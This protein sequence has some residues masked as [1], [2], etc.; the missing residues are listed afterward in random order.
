MVHGLHID[1]Q[2]RSVLAVLPEVTPLLNLQK[3]LLFEQNFGIHKADSEIF[4]SRF[5]EIKTWNKTC[6]L[7]INRRLWKQCDSQTKKNLLL[8]KFTTEDEN[9]SC[10]A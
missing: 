5:V 9:Y 8:G 10:V 1:R 2:E 4:L 6:I 7:K 3:V